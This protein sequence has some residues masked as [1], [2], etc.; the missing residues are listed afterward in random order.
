MSAAI[1]YLSS[2]PTRPWDWNN[3][4]TK[5]IFNRWKTNIFLQN[6]RVF[7]HFANV[8]RSHKHGTKRIQNPIFSFLWQNLMTMILLKI[9]RNG[10]HACILKLHW[11]MRI[12]FSFSFSVSRRTVSTG[13]DM[14]VVFFLSRFSVCYLFADDKVMAHAFFLYPRDT[15]NGNRI[16]ARK[17]NCIWRT[18]GVQRHFPMD[19]YRNF[20]ST[21]CQ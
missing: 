11:I 2:V 14:L 6:P 9:R 20:K 17:K 21:G 12:F 13:F 5:G 7:W 10:G 18:Y 16:C 19:F 8:A 4:Y 1:C 3:A 15:A